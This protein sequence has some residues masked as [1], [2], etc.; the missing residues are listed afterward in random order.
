M[1]YWFLCV[2]NRIFEEEDKIVCSFVPEIESRED[3]DEH[4]KTLGLFEFNFLRT[5][6]SK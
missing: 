2:K 1:C 3:E 5:S 4:T 6:S